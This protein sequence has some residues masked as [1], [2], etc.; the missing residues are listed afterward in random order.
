MLPLHGQNTAALKKYQWAD[1][2]SN[3][4]KPRRDVFVKQESVKFAKFFI[5]K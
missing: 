3:K 2:T 4:I 1:H 5:Y